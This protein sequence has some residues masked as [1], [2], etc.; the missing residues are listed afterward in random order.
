MEQFDF[1]AEVHGQIIDWCLKDPVYVRYQRERLELIFE[2]L[3]TDV[4]S[5]WLDAVWHPVRK[6]G[7][8][9]VMDGGKTILQTEVKPWG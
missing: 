5:P 4:G 7:K 2:H 8:L 6:K 9:R 3:T 1:D